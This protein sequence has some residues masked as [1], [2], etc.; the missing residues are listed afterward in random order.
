[1]C[2]ERWELINSSHQHCRQTEDSPRAMTASTTMCIHFSATVH[3]AMSQ[4]NVVKHDKAVKEMRR[5]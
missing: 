2:L 1:M 3:I 4:Q 5:K